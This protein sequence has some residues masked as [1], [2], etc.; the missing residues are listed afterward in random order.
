MTRRCLLATLC[1]LF[2]PIRSDLATADA[3]GQQAS[4]AASGWLQLERDRRAIRQETG[5]VSSE[6]EMRFQSL[7]QRQDARYRELLQN[8]IGS[9]RVCGAR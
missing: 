8:Q 2:A 9:Y 4:R 3:T 7:R 1:F 5:P 6:D